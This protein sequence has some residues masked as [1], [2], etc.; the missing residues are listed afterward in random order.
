VSEELELHLDAW[1]ESAL[2]PQL[3]FK[4]SDELSVLRGEL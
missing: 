4:L 3:L 1:L 2:L